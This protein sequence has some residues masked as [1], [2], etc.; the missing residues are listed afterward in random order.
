[1]S[2]SAMAAWR[3]GSNSLA[4][5]VAY[6]NAAVAATILGLGLLVSVVILALNTAPATSRLSLATKRPA[7]QH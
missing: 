7:L 4:G 5:V 2:S 6:G 3:A 1:M